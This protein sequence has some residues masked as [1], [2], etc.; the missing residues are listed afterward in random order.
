M[1]LESNAVTAFFYMSF[2][3]T[4]VHFFCKLFILTSPINLAEEMFLFL[5]V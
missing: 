4:L 1:P 5:F 2:K 3:D